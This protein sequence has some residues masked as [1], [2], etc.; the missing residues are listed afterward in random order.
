MVTKLPETQAI[1]A[2]IHQRGQT[3]AS[4]ADEA[5][6]AAPALQP[7]RPGVLLFNDFER[8][9]GTVKA[10]DRYVGATVARVPRQGGSH[11]ARFV[12]ENHGGNFSATL[13]DSPF[14]VRAYS[15][16]QFDYRIPQDVHID[17]LAKVE[18]RWYSLRFTGDATNY[19]NRDVNIA[20]AGAVPGVIADNA[21]HRATIDLAS[22][23]GQVTART[24]VEEIVFADWHVG[25]YME[26]DFGHNRRGATFY[27]DDLLLRGS[28]KPGSVNPQP[29]VLDTF[30][31]GLEHNAL[32]GKFGTFDGSATLNT[33]IAR[34]VDAASKGA[35]VNGLLTLDYDGIRGNSYGG[36]YSELG[37]ASLTDYNL[38]SFRARA[39]REEASATK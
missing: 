5:P 16:L 25:G 21:W 19:Q 29:L 30:D 35:L 38:L 11:A 28:H 9:L 2:L 31:D 17:L 33:A 7:P 34:T 27:I 26:L 6:T 13:L 4:L 32:G 39:D 22:A 20:N 12:N 24:R 8:D 1:F 36:Y 14:D 18:G 3:L 37:G 15:T 23:L 10:R